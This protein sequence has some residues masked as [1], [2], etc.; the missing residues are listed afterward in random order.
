MLW[1]F[2]RAAP[3]HEP[4]AGPDDG[5][6][7]DT[8]EDRP[9]AVSHIDGQHCD[10]DDG[11]PEHQHVTRC[12]KQGHRHG[13]GQQDRR[14]KTE[15]PRNGTEDRP[16]HDGDHDH[17][18]EKRDRGDGRHARPRQILPDDAGKN[19]SLAETLL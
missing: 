2:W 1:E 14:S 16:E 8:A 15:P 19:A 3:V 7:Q 6:A 11:R 12:P 5:R 17:R 4:P 18:S 13:E 10:D 9:A